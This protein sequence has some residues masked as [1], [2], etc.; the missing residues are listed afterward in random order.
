MPCRHMLST[1]ITLYLERVFRAWDVVL[2]DP[3][4]YRSYHRKPLAKLGIIVSG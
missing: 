1:W 2:D 4:L 3:N